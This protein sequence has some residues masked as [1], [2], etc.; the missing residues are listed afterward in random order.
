M[1]LAASLTK[2]TET[3]AFIARRVAAKYLFG[4]KN[5]HKLS[6]LLNNDANEF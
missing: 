4:K 1:H 6:I 2:K 5:K 3:S